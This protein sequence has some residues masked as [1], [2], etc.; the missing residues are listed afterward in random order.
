MEMKSMAEMLQFKADLEQVIQMK[1]EGFIETF[2]PG[3]KIEIEI[4]RVYDAKTFYQ[5][6]INLSVK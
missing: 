5:V 2:P 6:V 3:L 1:I 4:E